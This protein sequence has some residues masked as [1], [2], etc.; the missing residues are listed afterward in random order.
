MSS[1]R[2]GAATRN[3]IQNAELLEVQPRLILPEK[4]I[5]MVAYDIGHLE[6]GPGH[7]GFRSRRERGTSVTT[8][9]PS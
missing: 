1:E 5:T 4:L 6:G 7:S 3:R 2:G 8:F 9:V